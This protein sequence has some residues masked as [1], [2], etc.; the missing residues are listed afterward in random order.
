MNDGAVTTTDAG[1]IDDR[2]GVIDDR[3]CCHR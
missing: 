1:A 2:R 3:R